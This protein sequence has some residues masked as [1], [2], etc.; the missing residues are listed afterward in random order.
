MKAKYAPAGVHFSTVRVLI[1]II[2]E[3][4]AGV[5][6]SKQL[7]SASRCRPLEVLTKNLDSGCF[8]VSADT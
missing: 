4:P 5:V 8:P 3:E 6:D 2:L 1:K 7:G